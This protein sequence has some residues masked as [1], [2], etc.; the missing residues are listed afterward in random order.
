MNDH[1]AYKSDVKVKLMAYQK[2][3]RHSVAA[4]L[5]PDILEMLDTHPTQIA[6]ETDEMHPADLADIA[7]AFPQDRIIEFLNVLP[8]ERAADVFEYID[9]ELQTQLLE[10]MPAREAAELL[11]EMTPDDRTDALEDLEEDTYEE[12]LSEIPDE[13]RRETEHLI[14]YESDTAGGLMTT[15][16]VSLP[17]DTL[18]EEAL[19][20]VRRLARSNKKEAMH[21][22]YAVDS[23]G[24]LRGVL[25]LRELLAAPEG[26]KIHDV[27][28]SEVVSVTVDADQEEVTNLISNYDIVAIPVTDGD[29]KIVG[30]I[31][32]DDVIDVLQEEH[33]EDAQ[34]FGGMEALDEPYMQIGFRA[35]LKKRAGWLSALFLGEMLTTSAMQHFEIQLEKALVLALFIPL[36]MSSGGN[37]GSQATSLIIR[38]MALG[39]IKISDWWRVAAR[40]LPSGFTLGLILGSIGFLRILIWQK[41]GL[42][43]YGEHYLLIGLTISVALTAIVMFGSIAGSMLPFIMRRLG[44]DPAS[45]SAPFVA[46][47]VDVT[48]LSIYFYVAL[49]ILR[50]TL[51]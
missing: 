25:S 3:D 43:D 40:E 47:L 29:N 8:P 14:S 42:Y 5:A 7:E 37:S 48:G 49:V 9:D 1:T 21:A 45:A 46:T 10:K 44:F 18:I 36:I 15:E 31:T 28:W 51:L 2:R 35:M 30:V 24:T 26:A 11:T 6:I 39:E 22:I 38:A 50:G 13:A 20:S 19:V 33:T 12:I 23:S 41:T 4:L 17:E 34:K 32:V 27:A 16:Y